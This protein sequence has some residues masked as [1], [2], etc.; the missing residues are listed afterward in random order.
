MFL[1]ELLRELPP[2]EL[3]GPLLSPH[4][5]RNGAQIRFEA[6]LECEEAATLSLFGDEARQSLD[7]LLT[8]GKDELVAVPEFPYALASAKKL[9]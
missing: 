1:G 2:E 5:E 7:P 3:F 4:P 9:A 8:P 6:E